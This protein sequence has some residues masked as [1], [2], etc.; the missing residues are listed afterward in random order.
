MEE[1]MKIHNKYDK[2]Q[3]IVLISFAQAILTAT[4]DSR[5]VL[6]FYPTELIIPTFQ[7]KFM[8]GVLELENGT[9]LNV[10]FQ[11]GNI[12]EEFL[13]RCAQYAMNLKA[14]TGRKVETKIFSTGR[15]V[16]SQRILEI[17]E[18]FRFEPEIIFYSEFDGR[19]KL[20]SIKDKI[21][22]QETLTGD[23]YYDLI[24]IPLMG[25]VDKVKATFEV[26][27][28]VNNYESF[29][30]HDEETIR[31]CHYVLAHIIANGNKK[32][33]SKLLERIKMLTLYTDCFEELEEEAVEYFKNQGRKEGIKEV[34]KNLKDTLSEEEIAER[35][36]LSIE[37][38]KKL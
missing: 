3:K 34:A 7:S 9:L 5:K 20:I 30:K 10:E 21:G 29:E 12:D 11:T 35:T 36:G 2:L 15:R 4:G 8:D 37:E 6:G 38:V 13:T 33:L 14:V 23:D 32:L 27:D 22:K 1:E 26:I 24:F 16:K 19:E 25:N 31:Q 18:K 17:S 28:I